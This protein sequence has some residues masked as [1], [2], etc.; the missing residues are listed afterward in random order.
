M[1]LITFFLLSWTLLDSAVVFSFFGLVKSVYCDII[2]V[3][4]KYTRCCNAEPIGLLQLDPPNNA[5]IGPS[6]AQ[7]SAASS[8]ESHNS[9]VLTFLPP[10]AMHPRY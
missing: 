5:A 2:F 9:N 8:K 10:D 1:I 4:I 3:V 6:P 7:R